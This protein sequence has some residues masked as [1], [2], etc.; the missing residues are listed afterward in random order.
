MER[1]WGGFGG[2]ARTEGGAAS[3]SGARPAITEDRRGSS[4]PDAGRRRDG[5]PDRYHDW[6]ADERHPILLELGRVRQLGCTRGSERGWADSAN[7]RGWREGCVDLVDPRYFTDAGAAEA[8]AAA[9]E[10]E[11]YDPLE[12]VELLDL[13]LRTVEGVLQP[14]ALPCGQSS[15]HLVGVAWPGPGIGGPPGWLTASDLSGMHAVPHAIVLATSVIHPPVHRRH[16]RGLGLF[17]DRQGLPP[18]LTGRPHIVRSFVRHAHICQGIPFSTPVADLPADRQRLLAVPDRLLHSPQGRIR[19]PQSA[20]VI[21][22]PT[23]VPDLAADGQPLPRSA[24]SPPPLAPGPHTHS[25]D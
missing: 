24:R 7:R 5:E 6:T 3:A 16:M 9:D 14:P 12:L 19:I 2:S 18:K 23:P 17:I 11:E 10:I 4:R 25:R 22:F 8:V 21:S 20:Q 1:G 15:D 13:Q